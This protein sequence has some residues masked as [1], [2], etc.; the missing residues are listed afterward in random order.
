MLGH[1]VSSSALRRSFRNANDAF[2]SLDTD[3][4]LIFA[5]S[6]VSYIL[7]NA[8]ITPRLLYR[9]FALPHSQEDLYLSP[10]EH[11]QYVEPLRY[12]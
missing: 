11:G 4:K 3:D 6:L 12:Y 9:N 8:K 2:T 5:I 1:L 10:N 7:Y